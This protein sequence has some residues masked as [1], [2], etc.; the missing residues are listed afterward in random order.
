MGQLSFDFLILTFD[1]RT[2]KKQQFIQQYF[3]QKNE[4]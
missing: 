1:F 2:E 3:S 4:G